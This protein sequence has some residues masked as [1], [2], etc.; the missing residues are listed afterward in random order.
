MSAPVVQDVEL[1]GHRHAGRQQ[2]ADG[3]DDA[4]V[5]EIPFRI[6]VL[7]HDRYA[8]MNSTHGYHEIVQV[9]EITMISGKRDPV[10]TSSMGEVN[11]IIATC[12]ADF[13]GAVAHQREHHGGRTVGI[14]G[15]SR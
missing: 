4:A 9:F 3:P 8:R 10:L 15:D 13:D 14:R 2:F 11:G 6:V 12:Q 7:A 1:A 5:S